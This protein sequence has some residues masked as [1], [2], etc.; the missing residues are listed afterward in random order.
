MVA[1]IGDE[2]RA[3]QLRYSD[4]GGEMTS[5]REARLGEEVED[6]EAQVLVAAICRERCGTAA[7]AHLR[8]A[9]FPS[10]SRCGNRARVWSLRGKMN[11]GERG[12]AAGEPS[13]PSGSHGGRHG[14]AGAAQHGA[15]SRVQEEEDD[16]GVFQIT[17]WKDYFPLIR[18]DFW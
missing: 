1:G 15:R 9:R 5:S 13:P 2:A 7:M 17:P 12:E 18:A 3:V 14:R 10:P 8:R 6:F 16:R 4:N 11:T